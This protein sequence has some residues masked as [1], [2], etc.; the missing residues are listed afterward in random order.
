MSWLSCY[1]ADVKYDLV[2]GSPHELFGRLSPYRWHRDNPLDV[3]GDN[4]RSWLVADLLEGVATEER[5]NTTEHLEGA[6][7]LAITCRQ[8]RIN[9]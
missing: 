6:D 5:Q 1:S 2:G 7:A 9:V 4:R 3:T 8:F